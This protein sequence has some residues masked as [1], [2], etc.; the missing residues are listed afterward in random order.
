M[1]ISDSFIDAVTPLPAGFEIPATTALDQVKVAPPVELVIVY[2]R[3]VLLHTVCAS[4][5]VITAVGCTV[6][7]RFDGVPGHR[8]IVG[9]ST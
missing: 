6:T 8:P 1:L 9:V 4:E 2:P 3:G 7:I 5:L